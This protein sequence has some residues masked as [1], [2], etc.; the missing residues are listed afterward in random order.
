[1]PHVQQKLNQHFQTFF[2]ARLQS[3]Y[4]LNE[5]MLKI[6]GHILV[7]FIINLL[8]NLLI[9]LLVTSQ[10]SMRRNVGVATSY[11]LL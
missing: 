6:W 8:A 3:A 9:C 2:L 5:V 4:S 11:F 7:Y 1:M 10:E